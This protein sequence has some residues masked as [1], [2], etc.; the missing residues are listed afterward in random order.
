[1]VPQSR[2]QVS[3]PRRDVMVLVLLGD[4]SPRI[5]DRLRTN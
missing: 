5:D 2:R 1:M 3:S 4:V